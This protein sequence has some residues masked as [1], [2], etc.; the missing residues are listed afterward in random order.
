MRAQEMDYEWRVPSC[1]IEM[2]GDVC[3]PLRSEASSHGGSEQERKSLDGIVHARQK[4]EPWLLVI[5]TKAREKLQ[6]T[7]ALA[8]TT[9]YNLWRMLALSCI[10]R[11]KNYM[12]GDER[13]SFPSL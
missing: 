6:F 2:C 7:T 12:F 8:F 9:C 4:Y 1:P 5:D 10:A 3:V 13:K 11:K